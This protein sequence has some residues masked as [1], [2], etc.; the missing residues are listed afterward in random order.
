MSIGMPW[1]TIPI[2]PKASSASPSPNDG[3]VRGRSRAAF[4]RPDDLLRQRRAAAAPQPRGA[5]AGAGKP[6]TA[7][8]SSGRRGTGFAERAAV[9]GA[10]DRPDGGKQCRDGRSRAVAN[11]FDRHLVR[12]AAGAAHGAFAF[13]SGRLGAAPS[14]RGGVVG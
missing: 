13:S 9:A 2:A 11:G 8:V 4:G 10:G 5:G 12:P 7:A 14:P 6:G 3:A 1:A